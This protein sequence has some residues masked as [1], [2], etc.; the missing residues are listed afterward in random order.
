M[1]RT[2]PPWTPLAVASAGQFMLVLDVSVVNVALP[3]IQSGL[4]MADGTVQWVVTGY[5][6]TFAGGLLVGGRLTDL[7]GVRR[8][9]IAGLLLFTAASMVGGLADSAAI[10]IAARAVQGMGAAIAS[11]ATLTAITTTYPEGSLRTR[12][13]AVW[14][15]VSLVGG[16]AGTIVGGLLTDA[17][18]WRAVLLINLPCGAAVIVAARALPSGHRHAPARPDA[19][20]AV[21]ITA[22]LL[23]LTYAVSSASAA[24]ASA[25]SAVVAAVVL[26]GVTILYQR[27]SPSP[28]LPRHLWH[29]ASLVRGN[30]LVLA[31][32]A[33]F[34]APIWLFLTYV[35]QGSLGLS[36]AQAGLGFVP[37]TV[38]TALVGV[39]AAPALLRHLAPF[40]VIGAGAAIT[41]AGLFW[42]ACAS[43][44]GFVASILGPSVI[45]GIGGG[46][47]NTPLSIVATSGVDESDAG[48]ASGLLNTA[49]QLGGALGL[50]ALTPLT[51]GYN[52]FGPAFAA[53]G[54][55][56]IAVALTATAIRMKGV[57]S[58]ARSR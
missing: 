25:V 26:L 54:G 35:M 28:L 51:H 56:M 43:P 30:L 20:G 15:A 52:E 2:T 18:S 27:A 41:A 58:H 36:P 1:I 10:L 21:L 13:I 6:L 7:W 40:T 37:L 8:V 24:S 16:G 39:W 3:D 23:V 55:V 31:V 45:I 42:P 5:A 49:K 53:L 12:A 22:T 33:C 4:A 11:P 44:T 32:G 17:V 48:A 57:D 9:F 47:L 14:T 46:L 38:V 34:Q 19:A 29:N 50:A